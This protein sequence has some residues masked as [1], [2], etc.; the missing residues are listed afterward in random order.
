MY[1][2]TQQAIIDAQAHVTV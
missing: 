1:H 2:I